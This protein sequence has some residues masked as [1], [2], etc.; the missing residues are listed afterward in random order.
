MLKEDPLGLV[1]TLDMQLSSDLAWPL[2]PHLLNGE[3]G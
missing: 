2:F 1:S 3:V